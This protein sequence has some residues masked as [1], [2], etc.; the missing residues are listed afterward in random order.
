MTTPA[1]IKSALYTTLRANLPIGVTPD[2]AL[3]GNSSIPEGAVHVEIHIHPETI[4]DHGEARRK[5]QT[6]ELVNAFI[7]AMDLANVRQEVQA[8]AAVM[9]AKLKENDGTK[10]HWSKSDFAWLL[11]RLREE[12]DELE[13]ALEEGNPIEIMREAAD[14]GNFAMMISDN[15]LR[16]VR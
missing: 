10:S 11:E 5:P 4:G 2:V 1:I 14:V 3:V 6:N 9:E 8:F 12:V 7:A 13:A 16:R 15:A